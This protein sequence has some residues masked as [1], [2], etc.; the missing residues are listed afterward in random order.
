MQGS[1]RASVKNFD[2]TNKICCAA[3]KHST[4]SGV[5]LGQKRLTTCPVYHFFEYTLRVAHTFGC[6]VQTSYR[7]CVRQINWLMIERLS[8]QRGIWLHD[9]IGSYRVI[10]PRTLETSLVRVALKDATHR[11]DYVL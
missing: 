2:L 9:R 7:A 8:P 3:H 10:N 6:R 4:A 5:A 11:P 1:P